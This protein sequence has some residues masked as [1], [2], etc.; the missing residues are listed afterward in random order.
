MPRSAKYPTQGPTRRHTGA[1]GCND[2]PEDHD[3]RHQDHQEQGEVITHGI[4]GESY[5]AQRSGG[6]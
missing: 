5:R 1:K 6:S 3:R 4:H 2:A